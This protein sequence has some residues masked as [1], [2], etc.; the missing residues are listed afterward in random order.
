VHITFEIQLI[1]LIARTESPTT[2]SQ[3]HLSE[4]EC[5]L[6]LPQKQCGDHE[7]ESQS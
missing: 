3:L 5:A 7:Y 2:E 1:K 4:D 6:H